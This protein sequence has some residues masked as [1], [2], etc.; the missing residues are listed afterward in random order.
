VG[1]LRLAIFERLANRRE[2]LRSRFACEFFLF[3]IVFVHDSH[4]FRSRCTCDKEDKPEDLPHRG[5]LLEAVCTAGGLWREFF[6][7]N[8]LVRI[9]FIIEMI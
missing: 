6:I 3:N 7:D 5:L 1:E 9:H 8:L 2:H 4:S